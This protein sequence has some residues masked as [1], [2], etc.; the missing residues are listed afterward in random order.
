MVERAKAHI[1]SGDIFQANL[2]QRLQGSFA[3]C[4]YSLYDHLQSINPSPFASYFDFGDFA[5]VS[6]SPE[7]LVKKSGEGI[8]TRPIAGTRPRGKD[9][10]EDLQKR[11]ELILNEKERAE[12]LMLIDLERNDLGRV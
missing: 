7:R 3:G 9:S 11:I 6:S 4:P 5:I 12:H 10:F 8:E 2:S 1:R